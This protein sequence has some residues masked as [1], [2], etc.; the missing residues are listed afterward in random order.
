V[1]RQIVK[2]ILEMGQEAGATVIAEGVQ[3]REESEALLALGL[4]YAQGYYFARPIDAQLRPRTQAR[5]S[6]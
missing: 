5:G 4:R 2:A 1:A 6:A 3:T